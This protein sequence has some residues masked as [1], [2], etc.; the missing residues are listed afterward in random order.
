MAEFLALAHVE[1]HKILARVD[2]RAHGLG[3]RLHARLPDF[4]DQFSIRCH[5]VLLA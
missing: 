5:R 3:R 1:H 4:S 2:P